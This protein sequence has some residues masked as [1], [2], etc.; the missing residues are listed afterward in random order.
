MNHRQHLIIDSL[1]QIL[2]L[3]FFA[4]LYSFKNDST[5]VLKILPLLLTVWQLIN[6]IISYKFFERIRKKIYVRTAGISIGTVFGI[7]GI[8]WFSRDL[9]AT[10]LTVL[11]MVENLKYAFEV[12]ILVLCLLFCVWYLILT[13]KE[14]YIVLFRTV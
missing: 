6:G 10:N 4:Y 8:F 14:M 13:A 9:L 3:L 7:N 5:V 1:G 11:S 12:M 2:I